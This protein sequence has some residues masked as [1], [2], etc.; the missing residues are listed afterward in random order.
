MFYSLYLFD[1]PLGDIS[2]ENIFIN[3]QGDLKYINSFL[4]T[5]KNSSLDFSS[6]DQSSPN[7]FSPEEFLVMKFKTQ[8]SIVDLDNEKKAIF[9]F[10]ITLLSLLSSQNYKVFY[11]FEDCN[12]K[13]DK[14]TK[15]LNQL[16]D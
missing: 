1:I 2:P 15:I 13:F 16:E 11:D 9:S 12:I 4:L 7:T 14:I 5:G 6:F 3:D 8:Q 10:G